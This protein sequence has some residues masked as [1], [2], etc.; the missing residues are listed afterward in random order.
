MVGILQSAHSLVLS[1]MMDLEPV[2]CVL[3]SF[4]DFIIGVS[5]IIVSSTL[6]LVNIHQMK[7]GHVPVLERPHLVNEHW[8]FPHIQI[9]L[10]IF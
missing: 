9:L 7:K 1:K 2:A 5:N 3:K 6:T 4:P 8:R 10:M